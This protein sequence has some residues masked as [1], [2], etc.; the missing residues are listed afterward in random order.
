ML[1]FRNVARW[2]AVWAMGAALGA[3]AQ[4]QLPED[5]YLWL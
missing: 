3:R 1:N 5:K 4:M 2:C